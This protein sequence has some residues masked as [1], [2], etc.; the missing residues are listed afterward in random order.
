[1][2]SQSIA[3]NVREVWWSILMTECCSN[4][5]SERRRLLLHLRNIICKILISKITNLTENRQQAMLFGNTLTN[6]VWLKYCGIRICVLLVSDKSF[7]N[8]TLYYCRICYFMTLKPVPR[9]YWKY[10]PRQILSI[11]RS[12]QVKLPVAP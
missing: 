8:F 10:S 3:A 1:M 6:L 5:K 4:S 12:S 9:T 11:L 7:S 2:M